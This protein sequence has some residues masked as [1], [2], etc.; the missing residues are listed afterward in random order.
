MRVLT[1]II[2]YVVHSVP[3]P[4]RLQGCCRT[5]S[6]VSLLVRFSKRACT[7]G[8]WCKHQ[9]SKLHRHLA[10]RG[11]LYRIPA[12][13]TDDAED[14]EYPEYKYADDA[15][16]ATRLCIN[17]F[18]LNVGANFVHPGARLKMMTDTITC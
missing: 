9:G 1:L 2:A 10:K 5:C 6:V 11:I 3:W 14:A 16:D 4:G 17:T 12:Y 13:N 15:K 18:R 7:K 8:K